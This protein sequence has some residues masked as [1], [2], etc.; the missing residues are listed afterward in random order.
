MVLI[1]QHTSG[2]LGPAVPVHPATA[3]TGLHYGVQPAVGLD[4]DDDGH[5][6]DV[7]P[8]LEHWNSQGEIEMKLVS[9]IGEEGGWGRDKE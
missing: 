8:A 3:A 5:V 6:P 9:S 2:L 4:Q 7:H 1:E